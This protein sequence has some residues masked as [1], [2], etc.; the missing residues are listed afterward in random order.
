ME[1][2]NLP[3]FK[4]MIIFIKYDMK[5]NKEVKTKY[6]NTLAYKEYQEKTRNYSID[7]WNSLTIGMNDILTEFTLKMKSGISYD[8]IEVLKIVGKLQNYI[9]TNYYLCTKEI[10]KSLGKMGSVK[11]FV[12]L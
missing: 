7:K 6:G 2:E 9:T 3:F 10:L 5:E 11:S 1:D 8:S 4:K 12:I